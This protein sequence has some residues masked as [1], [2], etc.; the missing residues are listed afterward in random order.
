MIKIIGTNPQDDAQA[1]LVLL[2]E[3]NRPTPLLLGLAALEL[4][5]DCLVAYGFYRLFNSRH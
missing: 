2:D 1:E 4:A 3:A 5:V